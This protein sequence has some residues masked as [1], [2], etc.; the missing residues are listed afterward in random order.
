M[1][2]DD[3]LELFPPE[4]TQGFESGSRVAARAPLAERMRPRVL[5]EVLG[6]E[7]LLR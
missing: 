4:T 2:P 5:D 7:Q 6:Q 1:S 3:S